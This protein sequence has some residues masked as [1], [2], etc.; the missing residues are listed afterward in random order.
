MAKKP[1][2][3]NSGGKSTNQS[4]TAGKTSH[5][6]PAKDGKWVVRNS[7]AERASK[8]FVRQR[9]AIEWARGVARQKASEVV[10]HHRDGTIRSKDS[11]AKDPNPPRDR[12][13]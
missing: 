5:V 7:G 2:D 12:K 3:Q 8:T 13:K 9:D 1:R 10:I 4:T 11:Y 6:I